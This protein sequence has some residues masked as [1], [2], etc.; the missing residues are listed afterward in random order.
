VS[1]TVRQERSPRLSGLQAALSMAKV[2][3]VSGKTGE[4]AGKS[5]LVIQS[6]LRPFDA[7]SA[8]N[9]SKVS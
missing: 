7:H 1:F 9:I 5:N 8:G 4:V 2:T 6:V 3:G